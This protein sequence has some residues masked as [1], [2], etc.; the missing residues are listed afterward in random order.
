MLASKDGPSNVAMFMVPM[1]DLDANIGLVAAHIAQTD[2]FAGDIPDLKADLLPEAWNGEYKVHLYPIEEF[3]A[4]C[5]LRPAE[6]AM[7]DNA[8]ELFAE[9]GI[10]HVAL[11]ESNIIPPDSQSWTFG[12]DKISGISLIVNYCAEREKYR[13]LHCIG[14]GSV[15]AAWASVMQG[16]WNEGLGLQ[17][18]THTIN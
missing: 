1:P 8:R 16:E 13:A 9:E 12:K 17:S 14:C 11:L 6:F 5:L 18:K 3:V 10:T 15:L 4:D 2:A 7:K